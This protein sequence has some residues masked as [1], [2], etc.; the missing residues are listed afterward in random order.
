LQY[1]FGRHRREFKRWNTCLVVTGADSSVG[2]PVWSS[3]ARIQALESGQDAILEAAVAQAERRATDVIRVQLQETI[4]QRT[5]KA[6]LRSYT[7]VEQQVKVLEC[8]LNHVECSLNQVECPLN[9]V[10]CPLNYVEC[11]LLRFERSL[12][13]VKCSLSHVECSLSRV[14]CS[15]TLSI[16]PLTMLNVPQTLSNVT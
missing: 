8:S 14:E 13:R 5:S 6:A 4:D 3:Q 16:V 9:Q 7:G 11:A 15:L 10:E 2:I 12:N 1:L